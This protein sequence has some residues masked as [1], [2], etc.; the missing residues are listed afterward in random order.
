MMHGLMMHFPLTVPVL[1]RRAET[2]YVPKEI[3]SY[4]LDKSCHRYTYR[5]LAQ[6]AQKLAVAL[7]DLGIQSGDRVATL[8]WNHHQHVEALFGITAA[9]A[10]VHTLNPRLHPDD[11]AYIANDAQD[12][13]FLVDDNL[14]PLLEQFH[15]RVARAPV[16]VISATKNAPPGM[17][18]YEEILAKANGAEF[19][20]PDLDENQA[21]AMCYTSGTTGKPKGVLYS[22]RAIALQSMALGMVDGLGVCEADV[23]LPVAPIY[24]A[25]AWDLPFACTL[26]GAQQVYVGPHL[27]PPGLLRVLESERAT[28]TAGVPTIWLAVLQELDQ[29]SKAYDLSHLRVIVTGGSA[30]PRSMI[31]GFQE[32]HGLR[33]LH[34]WGMT[35]TAPVGSI[36][37]LPCALREASSSE[38]FAYRAK[39]GVPAP[40]I[41]F[42]AR[43]A[44]GLVPWD[45]KSAG[46]LELRG[47][48]VASAYY[49]CPES[50][51]FTD[52]GWFRTGDIVAIDARG[53]IEIQDR[54]K[55]VIK[56][57]GEW[58]SSV[59][60]EN[61][62]MGHPAVAEAAVVAVEHPK[63][64]ERPLAVVVLKDGRTAT[65]EELLDYLAPHFPKWW[66]PDAT[67]FVSEIPRTSA[68]KFLKRALR[69]RFG[70]YEKWC[71]FI[72]PPAIEA[73]KEAE[74]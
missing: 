67:V 7:G 27:D 60:L 17:L 33:V 18:D 1:L 23:V 72:F 9:G 43:G 50:A 8:C 64:Q 3:V 41:E 62:L 15:E 24:H 69:E 36:G 45:G 31:Q 20:Y 66:L 63:W 13:L 34:L 65:A 68:G 59:A 39:Q 32:R 29:N 58:I 11:L 26:A 10:V 57:G 54:A 25:N 56:S 71:R 37:Y 38:Q 6:R 5:D 19:R 14:L 44:N 74:K 53:C 55:D 21:A 51:S 61:A 2:L 12:K 4:H 28:F 48:W 73:A 22:H 46:E 47:P 70:G 40:F 49:N 52:D 16:V 30:A 35:E 42:R